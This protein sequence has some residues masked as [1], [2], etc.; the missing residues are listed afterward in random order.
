MPPRSY[1]TELR[2]L[3]QA[4]LKARIAEAAVRLHAAQ[5]ALATSYAQVAAE[6]GVS[7]PTVYKHFPTLDDLITA[8]T[9]HVAAQAPA[10]P[11][12]QLAAAPDL[13]AAAAV[14]VEAFD[15]LHAHFAP[16][17]AWREERRLPVLLAMVEREREACAAVCRSVLQRHGAGG[18]ELAAVWESL[19]SFD[20][21]HR[22]V[23]AH[24]L[25]RPAARA[26]LR[27]LLLAATGPL[28]A[29]PATPRPTRKSR[30]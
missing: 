18:A 9:G 6:A 1:N 11:Q 28:P 24:G 30:P 3:Q 29:T 23:H 20:V 4:D 5:G 13:A 10:F 19:L 15:R 21:W 14:L 7:L 26:R 17:M 12:E 22:L 25:T 2:Q 27:H 8:C 16:W